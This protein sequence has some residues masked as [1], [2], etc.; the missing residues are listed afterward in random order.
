MAEREPNGGAA[1]S[2]DRAVAYVFAGVRRPFGVRRFGEEQ[3]PQKAKL[4]DR[5]FDALGRIEDARRETGAPK[6]RTPR[7]SR[8]VSERRRQRKIEVPAFGRNRRLR[9]FDQEFERMLL[10]ARV[11]QFGC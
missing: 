10:G 3:Q 5:G 8:A 2:I 7:I 4:G 1:R 9:F 6:S 11:R